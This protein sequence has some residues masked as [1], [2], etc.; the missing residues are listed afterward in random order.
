MWHENNTSKCKCNAL[1]LSFAEKGIMPPWLSLY[2]VKSQ[3]HKQQN[4]ETPPIS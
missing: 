2:G 1:S 4:R 3:T